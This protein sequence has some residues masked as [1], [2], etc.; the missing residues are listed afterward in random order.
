M[1]IHIVGEDSK[2]RL[3]FAARNIYT[4]P[5]EEYR[6]IPSSLFQG[7]Y[8][9]EVKTIRRIEHIIR[10]SIPDDKLSARLSLYPQIND[11]RVLTYNDVA[12]V[13]INTHKINK[14]FIKEEAV[15]EA[16]DKLNEGFIVEN[17]LICEGEPAH[18]GKNAIIEY[19]FERPSKKPK[20]LSNG[21]VD[22]REFTKFVLVDKDQIVIRRSPPEKGVNGKDI[23]GAPIKALDGVDRDVT[24]LDG[25]Y[26]NLEKT[27]YKAKYNGHIVQTDNAITI[28]PVLQVDGDVDMRI[29]NL[30]FEG[31]IYVTGNVRSGFSIDA[32]DI[33]VDGIVENAELRARNS[34]VVKRGLKGT[35]GKGF[36]HSGGNMNLGYCENGNI[37][38][39]G[40]FSVEKYCF[41]SEIEAG[42]I[43]STGKDSNISGGVLKAFSSVKAKNLGSRNSGKM[44]IIL[45]YSPSIQ[46]K[47]EK[48]KIEINQVSES[49]EKIADVLSKVD[50][51]NPRIQN[52]SKIKIL[53][54]T[55]ES[56]KRRLPLLEKKYSDLQSKSICKAPVVEVEDKIYP[57]VVINILNVD[58][59]IRVEMSHV[60]FFYNELTHEIDNKP[61]NHN[62]G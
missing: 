32:D 12:S 36:L 17:V 8:A 55:A 43:V 21:K 54:D 57:G 48:V 2:Q 7:E 50:I 37:F 3:D 29:G 39:G 60:E 15:Q 58:R 28:L 40:E 10:V 33:I 35:I 16:I 22:Y 30:R 5:N 6:V 53:L 44:E 1:T 4:L 49:L 25:V 9:L 23:T 27:E 47:A 34:I 52:N 41:N 59:K 13:L 14:S 51:N 26:A 11:D 62:K 18:N 61:I 31:T 24:I 42:S 45:G 38:C 46:N 19:L 20:L 56:F